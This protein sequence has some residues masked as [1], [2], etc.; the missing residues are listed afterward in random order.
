MAPEAWLPFTDEPF[1]EDYKDDIIKGN[2]WYEGTGLGIAVPTYMEEVNSLEDLSKIKDEIDNQIVG[3]EAGTSLM[4]ITD[5]EMLSA[6]D[7]DIDL[8]TS[9]EPAMMTE[10]K[11]AYEEERP[12]AVTLWNPHWA[13]SEYDLKYLEDPKGVYGEPDDIYF[14]TRL[15]FDTD[16]PNVFEMFQNWQLNDQQLGTLMKY[17]EDSSPEEGAQKWIDENQDLIDSWKGA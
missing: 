10:L 4:D 14:L 1:Y 12:I 16:Y 2:A 3:I 13:F 11:K 17:I 5:K 6:Y 9:S 7:L 8:L 15:D